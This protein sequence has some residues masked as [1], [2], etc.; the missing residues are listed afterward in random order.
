MK[1]PVDHA[2]KPIEHAAAVGVV[3]VKGKATPVGDYSSRPA[4]R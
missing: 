2:A 1:R 3:T 4:L